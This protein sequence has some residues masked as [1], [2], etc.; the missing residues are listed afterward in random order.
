MRRVF[1]V[2]AIIVL[3][4]PSFAAAAEPSLTRRQG[5]LQVWASIRRPAESVRVQR[6]E[7]VPE[8]AVGEREI[9][10]AKY[11]GLLGDVSH[12]RP[13]SPLLVKDALVWLFKTRNVAS[14]E[15]ITFQTLSQWLEKYPLAVQA[16][17]FDAPVTQQGL[18]NLIVELD[19]LLKDEVHLVTNYGPELHGNGTAFGETFDMYAMTAAHKLLPYNTMIRVTDVETGLSVVV[20]INDRGPF[21]EG[22]DLDLSAASFQKITGGKT[23]VRKMRIERLGDV[24]MV[25][26]CFKPPSLQKTLGTL[27]LDP[28]IPTV[29][30][31]GKSVEVRSSRTFFVQSTLSPN[32]TLQVDRWVPA[33][34][35]FILTPTEKGRHAVTMANTE[36]VKRRFTFNVVQCDEPSQS[37]AR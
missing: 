22:R 14:P 37:A 20:R 4:S 1:S 3:L 27:T 11:R 25:G 18:R 12:F 6:Y 5:F 15:D 17:S 13:E 36:G 26:A 19:T 28:G 29:V 9:S 33:G 30:P 35:A 2:I 34:E 21:V 8:G 16:D 32:G 7:D 24:S 31:M 10:F 23:G